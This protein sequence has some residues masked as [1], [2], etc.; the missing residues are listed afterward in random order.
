MYG[1]LADLL[2]EKGRQIYAIKESASVYDAVH[3]MNR[4]K[5]GAVLVMDGERLAGI[6]TERDLLTRV[7]DSDRNAELTRVVDVMTP[8]PVVV[9]L[10][11]PVEDAMAMMTERR[12]RHL[13]VTEDGRVV[14]MVSIRDLMRWV[15]PG[16]GQHGPDQSDPP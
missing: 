4:K 3:E 8:D 2:A 14:G 6:F 13:P 11:M 7:V 9:D 5:V 10:G 15:M 1:R 16:P 12:F